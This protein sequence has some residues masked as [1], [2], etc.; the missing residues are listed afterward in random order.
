MLTFLYL[1]EVMVFPESGGW[2]YTDNNWENPRNKS[3]SSNNNS[4]NTNTSDT[5]TTT[6]PKDKIV[7][8]RRRWVRK[9]ELDLNRRYN[10]NLSEL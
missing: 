10:N 5:N 6:T 3:C 7:T 2:V 9:C 1:I 4:T 8:R